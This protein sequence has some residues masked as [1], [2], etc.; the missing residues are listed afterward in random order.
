MNTNGPLGAAIEVNNIVDLQKDMDNRKLV[1][2]L[3]TTIDNGN[4]FYTEQNGFDII[5]RK[6][7][8]NFLPEAAHYPSTA[9][10]YIQDK[11]SRLS[12]LTSQ[13]VG[14]SSQR[15]GSLEVMLDRRLTSDDDCGLGEGIL[16]NRRTNQRFYILWEFASSGSRDT[17]ETIISTPSLLAHVLVHHMRNYPILLQTRRK[18]EFV[19]YAALTTDFSCDVILVNLRTIDNTSNHAGLVLHKL[20]L[21]ATYVSFA[22]VSVGCS[23]SKNFVLTQLFR[24]LSVQSLV[25]TSLS[26]LHDKQHIDPDEPIVLDQMHLYTFRIS[27]KIKS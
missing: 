18:V 23:L 21:S 27:F 1:M 8:S 22:S 16:D 2:R 24:D 7:F 13:P 25:E 6:R 4:V 26:L 10:A 3:S 14:V 9:V 19:P 12:L 20:K 5:R 11:T 15:S 17:N